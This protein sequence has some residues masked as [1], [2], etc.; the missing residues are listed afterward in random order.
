MPDFLTFS[1]NVQ[2]A[3][4]LILIAGFLGIIAYKLTSK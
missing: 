1:S 2:I 4:A 3:G